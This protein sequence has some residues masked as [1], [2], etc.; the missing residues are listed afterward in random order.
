MPDLNLIEEE[1]S[2]L[3]QGDDQPLESM[4]GLEEEEGKGK[5]LKILIVVVAVAVLGGGGYY[6]LTKLGV[7]GGKKPVPVMTQQADEPAAEPQQQAEAAQPT[8]GSVNLVETPA[9]EPKGKAATTPAA[10]ASVAGMKASDMKGEYTVQ[11]S[12]FR[13]Q[14]KADIIRQ[15]LEEAGYPAFVESR[16]YKDGSWYTVR[17]G[18]YPSRK[19]AEKAAGDFALELRSNYWVDKVRSR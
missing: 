18:R 3:T 11:I 8:E 12:A 17:I 15:R 5:L 9:L 16:D 4:E 10:P 13:D 1:G 7:L 14:Q 19:D 2:G 6:L